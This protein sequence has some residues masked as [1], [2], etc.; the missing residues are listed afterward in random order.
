MVRRYQ[1]TDR[2]QKP[3]AE[4]CFCDTSSYGGTISI[5]YIRIALLIIGS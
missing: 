5:F 4:D 3:E 2:E 1:T